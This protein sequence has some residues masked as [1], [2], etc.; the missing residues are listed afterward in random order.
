MKKVILCLSSLLVIGG[1]A[2][3]AQGSRTDVPAPVQRCFQNNYPGAMAITWQKLGGEWWSGTSRNNGQ[4]MSKCCDMNGQGTVVAIPVTE[5]HIPADMVASISDKYGAELY[6]ITCVKGMDG[7]D[8]YV[9]RLLQ[10]G[11]LKTERVTI[12]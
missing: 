11:N 5:T 10:H 12:K 3:F 7:N 8:G 4:T 9:V 1:G 6:D 2:L